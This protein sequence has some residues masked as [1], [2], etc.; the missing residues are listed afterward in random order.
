MEAPAAEAQQAAFMEAPAAEAQQA[1]FMEAPAA[2]AQQPA[3][4]EAPAAEAQQPA[5]MEA[6]AADPLAQSASQTLAGDC[7]GQAHVDTAGAKLFTIMTWLWLSAFV[8]Y[9]NTHTALESTHVCCFEMQVVT[10][11]VRHGALDAALQVRLPLSLQ[12]S[13]L[14]CITSG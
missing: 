3:D 7:E 14:M 9:N 13:W 4:M 12:M 11:Q 8:A 10:H 5:D 1:A 2:E 6:P